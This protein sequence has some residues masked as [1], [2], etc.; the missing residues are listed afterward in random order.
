M[1]EVKVMFFAMLKEQKGTDCI[2]LKLDGPVSLISL[3]N[4]LFPPSE[5]GPQVQV[6]YAR[7]GK[8]STPNTEVENGDEIAFLPPLGGG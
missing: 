4:S 3:Y 7:N 1:I 5:N 2:T 6:T 8:M